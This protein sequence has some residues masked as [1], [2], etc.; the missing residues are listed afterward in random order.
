MQSC[1]SWMGVKENPS[2]RKKLVNYISNLFDKD[3][4]YQA[5]DAHLTVISAYH[6]YITGKL[7]GENPNTCPLTR[8][9]KEGL[10]KPSYTFIW[11]VEVPYLKPISIIF[12]S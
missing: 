11:N 12:C 3:L 2:R 4:Q 7:I 5:N 8:I 10:P 9:F 6:T 1:D